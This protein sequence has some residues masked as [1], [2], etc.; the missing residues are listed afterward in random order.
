MPPVSA[1][2]LK[3]GEEGSLHKGLITKRDRS[4][5]PTRFE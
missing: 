1:T 5:L 4:S 2:I 3:D